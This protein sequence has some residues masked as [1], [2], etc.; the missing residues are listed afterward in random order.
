MK[1]KTCTKCKET[2][3]VSEF[4]RDK[5]KKDGL[6]SHCKSCKYQICRRYQTANKEKIAKKSRRWRE[7][8]R[9]QENRRIG[10]QTK[11]DNLRSLELAHN[12]G[13]PWEDW[14]YEFVMADNGLTLYQKAVKL[15]RSF[16]AV[17]TGKKRILERK[18]KRV[19][20][21]QCSCI[22]RKEGRN[23]AKQ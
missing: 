7:G 2:K 10:K 15:G 22:M 16:Y 17:K 14:E 21:R 6:T 19:D 9:K 8:N 12:N 3:F 5:Q 23:A 20:T 18:L 1:T 11:E 4:Y 13:K